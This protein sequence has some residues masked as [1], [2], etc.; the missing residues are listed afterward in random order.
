MP[1]FPR[2]RGAG[3]HPP[4]SARIA[5][6]GAGFSG[7]GTAVYLRRAGFTEITA[8]RWHPEDKFW[9]IE[10]DSGE[11]LEYDHLVLATSALA[12]PSIPRINGLDSFDGPVFHSARWRHDVD[13]TDKRVAV[14][15]T[16]A[17]AIQ[18]V[19]AIQRQVSHLELFQRTPPWIM[20]RHDGPISPARRRLLRRIPGLQRLVRAAIFLEREYKVIAFR[21]PALIKRFGEVVPHRVV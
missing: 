15:G 1:L 21:H 17:S 20:P 12:E 13:L 8:A 19:P 16:G 5:I 11:Q 10:T 4:R 2:L 7:L 6:V 18:F 3:T 14:I 9:A